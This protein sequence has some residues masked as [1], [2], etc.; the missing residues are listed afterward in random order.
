M[1]ATAQGSPGDAPAAAR[2]DIGAARLDLAAAL[3]WFAR[4]NMHESVA[5]HM[6]VAVSPDGSQFLMNPRGRHF[7]RVKAGDLLL[8]DAHDASTLTRHGAPDLTAWNL[9]NVPEP[10]LVW[11][12]DGVGEPDGGRLSARS[13]G[14]AGGAF[15]SGRAR[16]ESQEAEG[17]ARETLTFLGIEDAAELSPSQLP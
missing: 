6:S 10:R 8:L 13:H 1:S 16:R 7:A 9:A 3:R 17:A 5:N 15:L 2:A 12:P 11:R 14:V 4:L